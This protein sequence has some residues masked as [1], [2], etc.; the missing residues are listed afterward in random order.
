MHL[1]GSLEWINK[2]LLQDSSEPCLNC[3]L[4]S[5]LG[6]HAPCYWDK[7]SQLVE[8]VLYTDPLSCVL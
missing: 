5:T 4:A 3:H 1:P 6:L 2:L 8:K 7:K